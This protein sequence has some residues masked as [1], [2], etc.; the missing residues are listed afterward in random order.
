MRLLRVPRSVLP[1]VH[2]PY[3]CVK[4]SSQTSPISFL[5]PSLPCCASV[6]SFL[7]PFSFRN[8]PEAARRK[9]TKVCDEATK[10]KRRWENSHVDRSVNSTVNFSRWIDCF[11]SRWIAWACD[12]EGMDAVVASLDMMMVCGKRAGLVWS[13]HRADNRAM[14]ARKVELGIPG[15]EPWNLGTQGGRGRSLLC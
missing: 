12:C 1:V 8:G 15:S 7:Q 10:W 11:M 13:N 9:A 3:L 14:C 2:A 6:P 4:S 5:L